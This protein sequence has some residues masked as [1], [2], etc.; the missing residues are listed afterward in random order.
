[1]GNLEHQWK[2]YKQIITYFYYTLKPITFLRNL[3][4]YNLEL[5]TKNNKIYHAHNQSHI[6]LY[7]SIQINNK[8]KH[9]KYWSYKKGIHQQSFN[10]KEHF[11]FDSILG[12]LA[13]F[14]L[15]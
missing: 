12:T 11:P 6:P 10:F 8:I 4:N 14:L 2:D 13:S 7:H 9:G 3:V 15:C 5:K 1:M